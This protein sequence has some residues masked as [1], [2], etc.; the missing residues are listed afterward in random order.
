MTEKAFVKARQSC[1]NFKNGYKTLRELMAEGAERKKIDYIFILNHIYH[2]HEVEILI[3]DTP[4]WRVGDL[5]CR[6]GRK[7]LPRAGN[8]G[9][10]P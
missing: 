9:C 8:T 6:T 3:A 10:L 5:F 4:I 7:I 2:N 1:A